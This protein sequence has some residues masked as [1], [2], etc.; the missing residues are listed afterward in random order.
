MQCLPDTLKDRVYY[1]P[2]EEG[3]EKAVKEKLDRI[4]AWKRGIDTL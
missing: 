2:T 3:S 4:K 1:Q